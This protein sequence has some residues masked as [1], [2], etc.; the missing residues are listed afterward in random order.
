MQKHAEQFKMSA[1][2]G[3]RIERF[4]ELRVEDHSQVSFVLRIAHC[5][6]SQE[7]CLNE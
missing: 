5:S 7:V 1:L 4:Y 2:Q 6:D 3:A